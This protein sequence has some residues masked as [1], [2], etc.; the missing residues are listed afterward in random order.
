MSDE[1]KE[2][3]AE[4]LRLWRDELLGVLRQRA[5]ERDLLGDLLGVE[6]LEPVHLACPMGD[7]MPAFLSGAR[8]SGMVEAVCHE[9]GRPWLTRPKQHASKQELQ[10]A[11]LFMQWPELPKLCP[12]CNPEHVGYHPGGA[13][14]K[15]R[16]FNTWRLQLLQVLARRA[17]PRLLLVERAVW[18]EDV[19][20]ELYEALMPHAGELVRFHTRNL[21]SLPRDMFRAGRWTF[22]AHAT[23]LGWFPRGDSV[24]GIVELA[25]QPKPDRREYLSVPFSPRPVLR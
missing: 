5:G 9:C 25:A 14:D 20:L 21:G 24:L 19:Q 11:I 17:A 15:A 16:W 10:H 13:P 12:V 22:G 23:V 8:S 6:E 3:R 1:P 4:L 7:F 2:P 18:V